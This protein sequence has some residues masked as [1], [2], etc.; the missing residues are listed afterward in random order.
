M[1]DSGTEE[2]IH[3][4]DQRVYDSWAE[5]FAKAQSSA[6]RE[7]IWAAIKSGVSKGQKTVKEASDEEVKRLTDEMSEK[8]KKAR[9]RTKLELAID[10]FIKG[11]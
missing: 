10:E 11:A 2:L 8:D 3:N 6:E 1:P 7:G 4:Y 5:D 9:E